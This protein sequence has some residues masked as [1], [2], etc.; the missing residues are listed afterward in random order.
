MAVNVG[1]IFVALG[2]KVDDKELKQFDGGVR[3]LTGNILAT[4]G[5]VAGAIYAVSRFISSSTTAAASIRNVA[6][7]TGIATD[8]LQKVAYAANAANSAFSFDQAVNGIANLRK[9]LYDIQF[10]GGKNGVWG[11]L[12]IDPNGKDIDQI[13]DQLSQK[14]HG[15]DRARASDLLDQTGLGRGYLSLLEEMY[16][17]PNFV[18]QT[19]G[20]LVISDKDIATLAEADRI[21]NNI[22]KTVQMIKAKVTVGLFNGFGAGNEKADTGAA[23]VKSDFDNKGGYF[24]GMGEQ[25]KNALSWYKSD[26]TDPNANLPFTESMLGQGIKNS[27]VWLKE[28]E[29]NA[30]NGLPIFTGDTNVQI[31][32][33]GAE[34]PKVTADVVQEYIQA[35]QDQRAKAMK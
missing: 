14:L 20:P 13:L 34:D 17:N 21:L 28:A 31:T 8:E 24:A 3:N 35:A 1:D 29:K 32:I 10:N 16:N 15:M 5:A 11:V 18:D 9:S 6:Q 33:N 27:L 4:T 7:E 12:G 2:F 30:N 22:W 19:G 26:H 23:A 25:F